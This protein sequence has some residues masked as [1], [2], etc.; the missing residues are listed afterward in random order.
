MRGWRV[1]REEIYKKKKDVLSR[2][3]PKTTSPG[4]REGREEGKVSSTRR[5]GSFVAEASENGRRRLTDFTRNTETKLEVL[6]VVSKMV[7]LHLREVS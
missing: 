5:T 7:L 2:A 1:K 6:V 3:V 4:R